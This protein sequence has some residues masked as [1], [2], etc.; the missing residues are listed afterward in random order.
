MDPYCLHGVI[1]LFLSVHTADP[2]APQGFPPA[3]LRAARDAQNRGRCEVTNP[4][5]TTEHVYEPD[6]GTWTG[7]A[8]CRA[9]HELA[10]PEP[11]IGAWFEEHRACAP[12]PE[13]ETIAVPRAAFDALTK[14]AEYVSLGRRAV[15]HQPD[16]AP[17]PDAAARRALGIL[18]D[19]GLRQVRDA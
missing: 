5:V 7:S 19:T 12:E 13:S 14:V 15:D 18:G 17:Y 16:G 11:E 1:T 6:T 3:N 8:S 2:P 4:Q 9:G 10:L